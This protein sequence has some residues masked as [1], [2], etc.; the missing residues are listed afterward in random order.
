MDSSEVAGLAFGSGLGSVILTVFGFLWLGWGFSAAGGGALGWWILF[1]VISLTLLGAAIQTL[2]TGRRLMKKYPSNLENPW[3][4]ARKTFRIVTILEAIG[5]AIALLLANLLHRPEIIPAGISLAVGL[6]FFPLAKLFRF[7]AYYA[8]ATAIILC[9]VFSWI[10]FRANG[11]TIAATLSTGI[12]LWTTAIYA[13]LR[14][15]QAI[16]TIAAS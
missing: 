13:L 1:Y 11:V 12:I 15:R 3:V 7:P 10:L 2:R 5:C 16:A 8:T 14:V 9:D 6:H 4:K